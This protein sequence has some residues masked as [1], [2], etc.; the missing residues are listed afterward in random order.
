MPHTSLPRLVALVCLAVVAAACSD[1]PRSPE[2]D[3][4]DADVTDTGADDTAPEDAVEQDAAEQDVA[5][6]DTD[7][8][9]VQAD[10]DLGAD[11]TADAPTAADT[12][13]DVAEPDVADA[14]A[15]AEDAATDTASDVDADLDVAPD[16]DVEPDA[17]E[18]PFTVLR[19]RF[20]S[21]SAVTTCG[22]INTT[23]NAPDGAL[24]RMNMNLC[25]DDMDALA[26]TIVANLDAY[27]ER[28]G[29][30]IL[31][32]NQGINL[33]ASWLAGCATFRLD[34]SP[35]VGDICLPWD[36]EYQ[37]LLGEALRTHIGPDVAGHPGLAG[38]YF[39]IPTMTNG[40][41]MHFRVARSAFSPY[42]GDAAFT[43]A[44]LDVMDVYQAAFDVPVLFEAGHCIFDVRGA[45]ASEVDCATPLA[46]YRHARD[47]YGPGAIGVALWNCA[48]RFW[49][50]PDATEDH[51][52]PLLEEATEDGVSMGCQTV[53]NFTAQPCRFTDDAVAD[54][55]VQTGVGRDTVCTP[56]GANDA[57]NACVDT[58]GWFAGT[59]RQSDTS[60]VLA[61]TWL[62]SWSAD[63][64]P[65][66]GILNTSALCGNVA[67]GF[68]RE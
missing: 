26:A 18:E 61:G 16:L 13:T 56:T 29:R 64:H 50:G 3:V 44:Y 54:Y 49:H 51:V 8:D 5:V 62:E 57:E 45:P 34:A 37:R 14:D 65:S 47:T 2:A 15:T 6:A 24:L 11:T 60:V 17:T 48:E 20:E 30:A 10:A 42:P 67:S 23:W 4:A 68:A 52:R 25:G 7:V 59:A 31:V 35:F 55:G 40:A 32:L 21:G 63:T 33:P 46:L 43:D 38:V 22:A 39:T 19:G 28:G 12:A 58:L 41:E 36:A 9:A 1:T 53:G 27:V 66:T